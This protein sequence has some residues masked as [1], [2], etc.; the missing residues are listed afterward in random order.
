MHDCLKV[1]TLGDMFFHAG[2]S[3]PA[4]NTLDTS[5]RSSFFPV[6]R[7]HVVELVDY[8]IVFDIISD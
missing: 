7:T 6:S 1:I 3:K 2:L 5:I 4:L 8:Y